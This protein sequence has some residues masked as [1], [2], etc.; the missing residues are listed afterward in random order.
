MDARGGRRA[1]RR[2]TRHCFPSAT[3]RNTL[4][5][6]PETM[7]P[8]LFSTT[9]TEPRCLRK[10]PLCPPTRSRRRSGS[11]GTP[12]ASQSAYVLTIVGHPRGSPPGWSSRRWAFWVGGCWR[13]CAAST[14]TPSGSW[15]PP[16]APMRSD[17]ASTPSTSSGASCAPTT[18]TPP[19]PSASTTGATSTP[20]T[21]SSST[22][23]T[24]RPSPAPV[25]W[26][27]P[28]S[29]PRWATCP[30]PCGSSSACSW[31]AR[32]RTCSSCS[33]R[34]A[35]AAAHWARWPPTRSAR[36]A[37]SW[38]PWSSSSCS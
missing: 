21:A 5:P 2:R 29:R 1:R 11:S 10:K 37:A 22:A 6:S 17:T 19:R 38:P 34:C 36:S 24:S 20:P 23:T 15:S 26:S 12:T 8:H 31:P 33:S 7:T 9:R 14:S 18:P 3:R 35:A 25:R 16:C 27:A 32:S 13:S 30:A 4:G 28:S